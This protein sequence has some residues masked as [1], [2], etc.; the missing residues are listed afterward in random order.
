[1]K[2]A[3]SRSGILVLSATEFWS[4]SRSKGAAPR[5]ALKRLDVASGNL[6][7]GDRV[8]EHQPLDSV[9]LHCCQPHPYSSAEIDSD[10]GGRRNAERGQRAIQVVRLGRYPEIRVERPVRLAVAEQVD[11]VRRPVSE[12]NLRGDAAPKETRRTEAVNEKD[13][14]SAVAIPLH[15]H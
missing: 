11:G 1:M 3:K 9:R 12:G 15:A 8:N 5:I 4:S 13:G 2:R 14:C 10:D 7:E 6:I